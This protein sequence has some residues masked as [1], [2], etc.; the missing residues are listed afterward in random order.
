MPSLQKK[1]SF[2][3][4][5][6]SSISDSLVMKHLRPIVHGLKKQRIKDDL[7]RTRKTGRNARKTDKKDTQERQGR[8]TGKKDKQERHARK[9]GKKDMTEKHARKTPKKDKQER[10]ARKASKKGTQE[11]NARES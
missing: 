6:D 8:K 10:H 1:T 7:R 2:E 11:R 4:L 9:E 5:K 3:V